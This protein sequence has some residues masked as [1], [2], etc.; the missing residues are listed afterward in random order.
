M[1]RSQLIA[2]GGFQEEETS[3]KLV[4]LWGPAPPGAGE[5]GGRSGVFSGGINKWCI[6]IVIWAKGPLA[7]ALVLGWFTWRKN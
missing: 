7:A 5:E 4:D 2:S 3:D 6:S 1:A